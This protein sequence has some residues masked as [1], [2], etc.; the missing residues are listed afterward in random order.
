MSVTKQL[1]AVDLLA[2]ILHIYHVPTICYAKNKTNRKCNNSSCT[3][4]WILEKLV[5]LKT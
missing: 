2:T 3:L 5:L 1:T 4:L